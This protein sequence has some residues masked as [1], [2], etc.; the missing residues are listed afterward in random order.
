MN[1]KKLNEEWDSLLA[2]YENLSAVGKIFARNRMSKIRR[3]LILLNHN[4]KVDGF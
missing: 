1:R 3:K 2:V 4:V